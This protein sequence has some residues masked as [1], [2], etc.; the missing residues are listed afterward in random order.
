MA[1]VMKKVLSCIIIL[2]V[3]MSVM[4]SSLISSVSAV[5]IIPNPGVTVDKSSICC[6]SII[7]VTVPVQNLKSETKNV[8]IE[9]EIKDSA[10]NTIDSKSKS[11]SMGPG[12][13]SY[14]TW[15]QSFQIKKPCE[16]FGTYTVEVTVKEGSTVH[17]SDTVTFT[18]RDCE[19]K[20][21]PTPTEVKF[22]GRVTDKAPEGWTGSYTWVSMPDYWCE[23]GGG[24]CD[25][26]PTV[27]FDKST[28]YEGNTVQAT[29]S[30]I[31]SSVY[32]EIIE[33]ITS[34][35]LGLIRKS[36]NVN[37]GETIYYTI[38]SCVSERDW[39]ICFYWDEDHSVQE[40][41]DGGNITAESYQCR[42]CYDFFVCPSAEVKFRGRVTDKAPEDWT[43]SYWWDVKVDEWISGE[44]PC[45]EIRVVLVTL[46]DVP[47]SSY[48]MTL[49]IGDYVEVYGSVG[50]LCTV[51]L[52]GDSYYIKYVPEAAK[53][54]KFRGEILADYPIISFYSFDVN[55]DEILDDPTG[56]LQ[57]DE[58]V[59][60][61]GHR[62]GP[63]QVDDVTVGDEVEAFGEYR[64]YVGT[65]EQ[66]F[67]S[68]CDKSSSDHY[69]REISPPKTI[70]VDDDF[71]D[72]PPNH[73]WNT[74]QEG[75]NDANDGDTILVYPGP[76]TENVD[77][78]RSHLTIK[79][80]SGN[81]VDTIVQAAVSNQNYQNVFTVTADNVDI[82]GFTIKGASYH[83]CSG[84]WLNGS[85]C[86]ISNNTFKDN[87]IGVWI[88]P[89]SLGNITIRNNNFSS[90]SGYSPSIAL[91]LEAT[92]NKIYLNNF[93]IDGGGEM[94][95]NL[96]NSTEKITYTYNGNTFTNY[97]GNYWYDYVDTDSDGDGIWDHPYSIDGGGKDNH[98]LKKNYFG[99]E[100][101][102]PYISEVELN[103]FT[104][105]ISEHAMNV[106]EGS[107][108]EI[109]GCWG[110]AEG[111]HAYIQVSNPLLENANVRIKWQVVNINGD[112][113]LEDEIPSGM[114]KSYSIPPG[115]SLTAN[116]K[117]QFKGPLGKI[118]VGE[119]IIKFELKQKSGI[120]KY[121][122][123]DTKEMSLT[124]KP[125]VEPTVSYPRGDYDNDGEV[126][127]PQ[128]KE[129][130]L[131]KEGEVKVLDALEYVANL[132]WLFI[133]VKAGKE[134]SDLPWHGYFELEGKLEQGA[135]KTG[136]IY[137]IPEWGERKEY[138]VLN[139]LWGNAWYQEPNWQ[140]PVAIEYDRA[141][142]SLILPSS[143][144]IIDDG[145][146]DYCVE[147]EET[148]Q[149][150]WIYE[151]PDKLLRS[152]PRGHALN[153][154][155]CP[156]RVKI[157]PKHDND[158]DKIKAEAFLR[159]E[160]GPLR[161]RV[162][163][164]VNYP[165]KVKPQDIASIYDYN[166]WQQ[167]PNDVYWAIIGT[168]QTEVEVKVF[169]PS[170]RGIRSV[171]YP[172]DSVWGI[173]KNYILELYDIS[174][175]DANNVS[176]LA[177]VDT[178][179]YLNTIKVHLEAENGDG[180]LSGEEIIRKIFGA[181]LKAKDIAD[182]YKNRAEFFA[183]S[184]LIAHGASITI[185]TI[186]QSGLSAISSIPLV[187]IMPEPLVSYLSTYGAN[188]NGNYRIMG[189]S[190]IDK[191][192]VAIASPV[193]AT[194]TDQYGRI[195]S[196]DGTNEIPDAD[197]IISDEIKIFYL[198]A[199]LTY[200]I[201]I[202]A[203]DTGTFN[204]TRVSP[205]G[206][207]ISITAFENISVTSS[208][209]ASVEIEPNV[210]DYTMGIDYNGDG[211]YEKTIIPDL[212]E[213][214]IVSE[215]KIIFDTR[216]ST[217]PYPSIPGTHTGTITPNQDITVQKLYT[218]PC[219]DTGG[220]TEHIRIYGHEIDKSA[221]WKGYDE[222]WHAI[223]FD[224]SFTL[225]SGKTYNYVIKTGSYPQI[226]H[227]SALQTENGWINCTEF[228]DANGKKSGDWIPAILLT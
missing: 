106:R 192:I 127:S 107:L 16:N 211:V 214:I 35:I 54:V 203:Y 123:I 8:C 158:Q 86:V 195:T 17:D 65:Y 101:P 177:P 27:V 144:D 12:P 185:P 218:Y 82:D 134:P 75:I 217:N 100:I 167:S 194:I 40:Q 186:T 196:D 215:N 227:T 95:E 220:H 152:T 55:I 224:S 92:G 200:S 175:R 19:P 128:G 125:G 39:R 29:V 25:N 182:V 80:T 190:T 140:N 114:L 173:N 38:P 159:L 42:K 30:T 183:A 122:I 124:V 129:Y 181:F 22:S 206:T 212:N 26:P 20:P 96:W 88:H 11:L 15:K 108:L 142:V 165:S 6:G 52:H 189:H 147:D 57:K 118:Q 208:T 63:A 105:I 2:V 104:K 131:F 221:S 85:H 1:A 139:I 13:Y 23:G 45:D 62:D 119:Y 204:F 18:V 117:L 78:T 76:Y 116:A 187:I 209:K 64:G 145:G 46:A 153:K 44:I 77:V 143:I 111:L 67:L 110:L 225:E 5:P 141:V 170:T 120:F 34:G 188:I 149:L 68:D 24:D 130:S 93:M 219:A 56:N 168:C 113:L 207:D 84:I 41:G 7:I 49:D 58:T 164:V 53:E 226:H 169:L 91:Y 50:M 193:N 81:P 99:G 160:V 126:E 121:Q 222:D 132:L 9:I 83:W 28:Y 61:Y 184:Y 66:I 33:P 98:P 171:I 151:A 4:Q 74:I 216:A 191:N 103:R 223:T 133:Q 3:V 109:I 161:G 197:M 172:E 205:I 150:T 47:I 146:A 136:E 37:N 32:Y 79:S 90:S 198:P 59:N 73:K 115:E 10:G 174:G 199:D 135:A 210:I 179:R 94:W 202:D 97:L 201:E 138:K 14:F 162:S 72:D 21:T 176:N 166:K 36:G 51:G 157:K 69:V 178:D 71:V 70:Y 156:Y 180:N 48:N 60:V 163:E 228:T 102:T 87:A 89:P 155:I 112:V 154:P 148:I 31:H 43:G 213:T 137:L